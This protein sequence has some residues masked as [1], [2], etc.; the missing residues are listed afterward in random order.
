MI[1][2]ILVGRH[3]SPSP[4]ELVGQTNQDHCPS[5]AAAESAGVG[6]VG[7]VRVAVVAG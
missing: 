6:A 2:M 4:A 5:T 1:L 7:E 3:R